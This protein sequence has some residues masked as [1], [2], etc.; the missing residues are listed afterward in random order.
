MK[1]DRLPES[2]WTVLTFRLYRGQ[3]AESPLQ[4]SN[5]FGIA[6]GLQRSEAP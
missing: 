5:A 3:G 1:S 4:V 2:V 6:G